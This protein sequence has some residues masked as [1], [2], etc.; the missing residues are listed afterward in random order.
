MKQS[1]INKEIE[2]SGIGLF[3]GEEVN[4]KLKPSNIDTGII[5][6]INGDRIPASYKNIINYHIKNKA[7]VK[8]AI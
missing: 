1:T 5:F 4:L 8:V 6:L 2:I 7:R 3:S